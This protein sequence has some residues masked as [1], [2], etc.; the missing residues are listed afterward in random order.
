METF[1][2][3]LIEKKNQIK[4]HLSSSLCAA[5]EHKKFSRV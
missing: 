2:K 5:L 1:K 3:N 4:F